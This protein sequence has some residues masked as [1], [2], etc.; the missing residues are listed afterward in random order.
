VSDADD[1]ARTFARNV[2]AHHSS[3]AWAQGPGLLL[4]TFGTLNLFEDWMENGEGLIGSCLQRAMMMPTPTRP[5][6]LM[7]T[8]REKVFKDPEFIQLMRRVGGSWAAT[9]RKFPATW[10]IQ[11]G[12]TQDEVTN[13]RWKNKT[14]GRV[15]SRYINPTNP[16][17]MLCRHSCVNGPY[18]VCVEE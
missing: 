16:T 11:V 6:L 14:Q 12:G 5:S 13:C 8:P 7:P 2:T 15:S 17:L 3:C 18:Q 10:V 1:G 4:S 9:A